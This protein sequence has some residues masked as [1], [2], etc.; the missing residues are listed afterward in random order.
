MFAANG[1]NALAKRKLA[2]LDKVAPVA[3]TER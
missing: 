3:G 1:G 2:E